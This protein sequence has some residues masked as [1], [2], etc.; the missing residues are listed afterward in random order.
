[1]TEGPLVFRPHPVSNPFLQA[2]G[3]LPYMIRKL[4]FVSHRPILGQG[5]PNSNEAISTSLAS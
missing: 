4:D 3:A 1:M 5:K 2:T